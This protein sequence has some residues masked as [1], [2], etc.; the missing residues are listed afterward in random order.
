MNKQLFQ[1]FLRSEEILV[2]DFIVSDSTLEYFYYFRLPR[3]FCVNICH[4][5]R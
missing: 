1:I 4:A 5:N 3:N 2:Y